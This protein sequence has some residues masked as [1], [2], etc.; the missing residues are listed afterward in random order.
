MDWIALYHDLAERIVTLTGGSD[1]LAHVHAGLILYLGTQLVL[2]ERRSSGT[3]LK[4]VI[5]LECANEAMDRLFWGEW[6]WWDTAGDAAATV[7]WPAAS[8]CVGRYRRARWEAAQR[9][10]ARAG[11]AMPRAYSPA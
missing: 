3:A 4:V 10:A 11:E 1:K 5:L 2:R 9:L 7:F 6:R 8:Y